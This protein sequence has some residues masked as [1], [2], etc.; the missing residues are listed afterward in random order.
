LF[1]WKAGIIL[2]SRPG[3]RRYKALFRRGNFP[4]TGFTQAPCPTSTNRKQPLNFDEGC[5]EVEYEQSRGRISPANLFNFDH[6]A[7]LIEE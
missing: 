4:N 1:E 6:S 3:A 5:D 7:W 2:K